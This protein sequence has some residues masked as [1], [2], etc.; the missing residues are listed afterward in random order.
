VKIQFHALSTDSIRKLVPNASKWI[1]N[2]SLGQVGRAQELL[3]WES[4][5]VRDRAQKFLTLLLTSVDIT[6]EGTRALFPIREQTFIFI[7]LLSTLVR[8]LI[9]WNHF[10]QVEGLINVDRLQWIQKFSSQYTKNLDWLFQKIQS[11]EFHLKQNA[12]PNLVFESFLIEARNEA[13]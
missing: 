13:N 7:R 8:D 6:D 4:D 12:D 2:A 3:A 1:L 11:M 5:G 10:N 9:W